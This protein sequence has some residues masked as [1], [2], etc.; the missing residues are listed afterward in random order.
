[1]NR[2]AES[3][4]GNVVKM[5]KVGG[6]ITELA[7]GDD[8]VGGDVGALA[9]DNATVYFGGWIGDIRAV[10]RGS[11]SSRTLAT[12]Q[13]VTALATD[14]MFAYWI[15]QVADQS[16][17][18]AGP[19]RIVPNGTGTPISLDSLAEGNSLVVNGNTVYYVTPEGIAS[20][21]Q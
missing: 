10:P 9:L 6:P 3:G 17:A 8:Y 4:V 18:L 7:G 21:P 14:G 15:N 1:M 16:S 13:S 20:R 11:G 12:S 2:G 5:P 19:W